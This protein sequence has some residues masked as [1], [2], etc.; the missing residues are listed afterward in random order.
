LIATAYEFDK[1]QSYHSMRFCYDSANAT[2]DEVLADGDRVKLNSL[3]DDVGVCDAAN[4]VDA[5]AIPM[6][7]QPQEEIDVA[8]CRWQTSA[9]TCPRKR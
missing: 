8:Y 2:L 6:T 9:Y 3:F 1:P 5:I 4:G 7:V